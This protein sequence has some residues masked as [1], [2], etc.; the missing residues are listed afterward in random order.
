MRRKIF[1]IV[2]CIVACSLSSRAQSDVETGSCTSITVGK[3]AS[4]DGSIMTSHT[5]DSDFRTWMRMEPRIKYKEGDTEPIYKGML[6]NDTPWDFRTVKEVGRIP[7]PAEETFKYL[8][9]AYPCL[10]E[11]Q[12]AMGETTTEGRPE[13]VNSAGLFQIEELQRIALQRCSTARD[14][15]RLM[16]EL[17]QEYGYGDWAECLTIA[18]K[19]EVWH[20]EIA[21][22]GAGEP[23][24]LWA[25]QRVPDDHISVSANISRIGRIEWDNPDYFMYSSDLKERA[26]KLGYWDGKEE[27]IFHK[28]IDGRKPFSIREFFIFNTLAP[29]LGLSMDDPELPFSIKPDQKVSPE[30]ITA[31]FRSTYEGTEWDMS[32]NL[33]VDFSRRVWNPYDNTTTTTKEKICPVSP[34][35]SNEVRTLLNE[36]KPDVVKNTRTIAVVRCSYSWIIQTRDWLPDGVG[37]VAYF[38]YDN[39]AQSPRI[40]IYAGIGQIHDAFQLCGQHTHTE[41]A[42]IWAYRQTNRLSTIDWNK[43]RGILETEIMAFEKKMFMLAPV[44]EGE[45]ARLINEGKTEEAEEL[46]T[47]HTNDFASLTMQRWQ[48]LEEKLWMIF[49]RSM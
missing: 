21:G 11:K 14:A 44:V 24:A 34:F 17:A 19:N 46:L 5:C 15:I 43:T 20:F 36:L 35:M 22:S 38:S 1:L 12:L 10:N 25:A 49:V 37:G 31:L 26:G 47:R 16:G 27:F 45:A 3:L 28:V 33:W 29:S 41:D 42:A 39:P 8:N 7:A 18:D 30:M 6:H 13:L 2:F 40:P 23:S 9:T 4:T 32:K 48:E